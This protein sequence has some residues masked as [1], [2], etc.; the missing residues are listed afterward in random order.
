[1]SEPEEAAGYVQII[2]RYGY[3]ASPKRRRTATGKIQ[4]TNGG[5]L[6]N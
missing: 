5:Y 6:S 3:V 2:S 1:M 4:G